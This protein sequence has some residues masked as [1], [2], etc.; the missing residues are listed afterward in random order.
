MPQ[1]K[2]TQEQVVAARVRVAGDKQLDRETPEWITK[3]A[4]T[5]LPADNSGGGMAT[6]E[7]PVDGGAARSA[8]DVARARRR[9]GMRIGTKP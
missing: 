1:I 9:R 5:R 6:D 4:G 2:V 7:G 8:A 3:L